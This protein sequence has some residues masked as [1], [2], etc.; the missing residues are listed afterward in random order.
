MTETIKLF[1]PNEFHEELLYQF[2]DKDA[3]LRALVFSF[4]K[5]LGKQGRMSILNKSVQAQILIDG[6]RSMKVVPLKE[7]DLEKSAVKSD[8]T[9][10]PE[11]VTKEEIQIYKL[12]VSNKLY[13]DLVT[14][15][16][17][18]CAQVDIFN[19]SLDKKHKDYKQ[20]FAEMPKCL[21]QIIQDHVINQLS[22]AIAG[23]IDSGYD[24]EFAE[25][26][27]KIEDKKPKKRGK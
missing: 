3:D 2:E 11:K 17:V 20:Q 12:T 27:K 13:E 4:L 10:I 14:F 9:W 16:Q 8:D 5:P 22:T 19:E 24:E 23:K 25:L 6:K 18:F 7:I 15:G 26:E 1:L 21:E